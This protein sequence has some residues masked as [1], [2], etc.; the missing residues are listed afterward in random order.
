MKWLLAAVLIWGLVPAQAQ[1]V[2]GPGQAAAPGGARRGSHRSSGNGL[3]LGFPLLYDGY[4]GGAYAAP[5]AP[6]VVY[7]APPPAA[8]PVI[9][10]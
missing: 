1:R 6:S 3:G 10:P 8:A 4:D 5:A 7:V 2:R 9:P